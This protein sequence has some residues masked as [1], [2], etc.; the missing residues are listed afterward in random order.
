MIDAIKVIHPIIET[1]SRIVKIQRKLFGLSIFELTVVVA[2]DV[3]D[4][5]PECSQDL[6]AVKQISDCS[7]ENY[8]F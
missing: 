2:V 6:F 4:F 8:N 5:F 1:P 3:L 7:C